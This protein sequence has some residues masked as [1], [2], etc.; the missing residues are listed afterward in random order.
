MGDISQ[1]LVKE[2]IPKWM[3]LTESIKQGGY[4]EESPSKS[5]FK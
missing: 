5:K 4:M 3:N 1:F 2:S